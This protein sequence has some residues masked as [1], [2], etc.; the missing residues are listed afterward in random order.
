MQDPSQTEPVEAASLRYDYPPR[1]SVVCPKCGHMSS[2]PII[3]IVQ[4]TVAYAGVC[5]ASIEP[6]I[7]CDAMVHLEVMSHVWPAA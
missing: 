1:A 3:E 7:W 6:G 2:F 5:G 4:H